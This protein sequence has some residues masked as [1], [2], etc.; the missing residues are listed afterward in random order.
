MST[1]VNT[2][3]ADLIAPDLHVLAVFSCSLRDVSATG[4][5]FFSCFFLVKIIWLRQ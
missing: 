3:Q 2:Q 4:S 5:R 1:Q